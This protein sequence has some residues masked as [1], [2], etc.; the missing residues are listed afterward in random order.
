[1]KTLFD[2]VKIGN[3]TAPNRIMRSAT[4]EGLAGPNGEMT[5]AL[6]SKMIELASGKVGIITFSHTFVSEEG[7][8]GRCQLGLATDSVMDTYRHSVSEIHR[9]GS[10]VGIQLNHAGRIGFNE[11]RVGPSAVT[12]HKL[13]TGQE[14]FPCVEASPA[15]LD[16]V[17]ESFAAAAQRAKAIGFDFV[18]LHCA[19][20]YLL[21]QFLS[22]AFNKRTDE[23]GGT[24]ENRARLALRVVEAV[25]GAVG[26][27]FPI[28][29]KLNT[30]DFHPEGL[31]VEESARVAVWLAKAGVALLEAS[32]G[33]VVSEFSGIRIGRAATEAYHREGAAA[34]KRALEM[35]GGECVG[36][37]VAL[38]GG[39]RN[40]RTAKE[41]VNEGVCDVVSLSRA[42][43]REPD[44]PVRWREDGDYVAKC[45]SCSKCHECIRQLKGF[46]CQIKK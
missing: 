12:L 9:L 13:T 37:V 26:P 42:L 7:R 35:E 20:G 2:P 3:I 11:P 27:E 22:P 40:G 16:A 41:M 39:V 4:W 36:T 44:L 8:A 32:G 30:Q 31:T 43:I 5:P 28:A 18:M 17:V 14:L 24:L 29:A 38:V 15:Y 10:I 21:S 6:E 46:E 45:V 19:H 1:M 34:W 25:R 33:S 23:Y